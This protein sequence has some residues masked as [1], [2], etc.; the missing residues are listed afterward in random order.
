M[1]KRFEHICIN[2]RYHLI[3][4]LALTIL[5]NTIILSGCVIGA[6]EPEEG[7]PDIP[8]YNT[9]ELS[10]DLIKKIEK[11]ME[12]LNS[13]V[14]VGSNEIRFTI[15]KI[16]NGEQPLH[17]E[18]D[19]K[20]YYYACAYLKTADVEETHHSPHS[21]C[22][23][24]K[25]I[26]VGFLNE[27]DIPE[28]YG[29]AK[30]ENAFQINKTTFCKDILSI[31]NAVPKVEYIQ[32]YEPVFDNG[33]NT[34]PSKELNIS[35]IYLNDSDCDT[36]YYVYDRRVDEHISSKQSCVLIDGE[37]YIQYYVS[38]LGSDYL[39]YHFGDC[40]E[41]LSSVMIT[42][43]YDEKESPFIMFKIE[44]FVKIF[45]KTGVD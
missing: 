22:C 20:N 44:D 5:L 28:Y 34:V 8:K 17:V 32:P 38:S 3:L 2:Y 13:K 18:F 12:L 37:Y 26:W 14:E 24:D 6:K 16:I 30:F 36:L 23:S 43:T 9:I 1:K 41:Y 29:E 27:T 45:V 7:V 39:K 11:Y 42:D 4:L 40:Y 15:G 10:G 33:F 35:F 21:Y 19:P 31:D 25:Y